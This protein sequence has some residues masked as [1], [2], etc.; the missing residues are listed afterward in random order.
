MM[1]AFGICF[2]KMR[3]RVAGE[4]AFII[5]GCTARKRRAIL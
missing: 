4:S 2:R 3:S 5:V 1:F